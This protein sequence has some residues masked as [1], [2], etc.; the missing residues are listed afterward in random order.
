MSNDQVEVGQIWADCDWR[1][2]G[3]TVRI[4]EVGSEHATVELHTNGA[5]MHGKLGRRTRIKLS[6]FRPNSTGYR[7]VAY[8]SDVS[9]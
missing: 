6:R 5:Y 4:I 7:L 9:K 2:K 8:A 1:A 3:R